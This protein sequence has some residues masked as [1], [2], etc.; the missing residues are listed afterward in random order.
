MINDQPRLRIGDAEREAALT[1]LQGA[2][3]EG[4]LDLEE[5]EERQ[6]R[7]RSAK[8]SDDLAALL[9]D[10]PG[11]GSGV[12]TAVSSARLA[13]RVGRARRLGPAVMS[14]KRVY[15]ERGT[16][17]LS[18]F[19]F[20]GGHEIHLDQ[21]M[22]PGVEI[23]LSLSAIMGGYTVHVPPGVRVLDETF[24]IMA[25]VG[26]KEEAQGNG[27]NGTLVLRGFLLMGGIEVIEV[28]SPN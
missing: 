14:G 6:E 12:V 5:L 23:E 2:Y 8:Y 10:L 22:G 18:G 4:R 27:S 20:W 9:V 7:C 11:G 26:I 3:T 16:P 24:S 25:G 17:A 19:A 1:T 28:R 13:G 21:A 15:L